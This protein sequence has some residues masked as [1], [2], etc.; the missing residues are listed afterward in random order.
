MCV[1]AR[2]GRACGRRG[3]DREG[4]REVS[5]DAQGGPVEQSRAARFRPRRGGLEDAGRTEQSLA[6]EMRSCKGAGVVDGAFAEL[7]RLF[8][9]AGQVMDL[10]TRLMWCMERLQ[11]L[12][13]AELVKKPYPAG[14]QPVKDLGAIATYVANKSSGMKYAAKLDSRR[15]RPR[16]TRATRSSSGGRGRTISPVPPATTTPASAS[17]CRGCRILPSRRRRRRSSASG[18]HTASRPP[19]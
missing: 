8:A 15:S 5:P 4:S 17:A 1:A 19:R 13:H 11:G 2:D 3:R 12:D 7:P 16:S 6:G 14:G 10:E 18:P 9:D